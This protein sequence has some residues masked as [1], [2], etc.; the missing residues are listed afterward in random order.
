MSAVQGAPATQQEMG[1]L[2]AQVESLQ[3]QLKSTQEGVVA[4]QAEVTISL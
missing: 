4:A 3:A 1:S 2:R